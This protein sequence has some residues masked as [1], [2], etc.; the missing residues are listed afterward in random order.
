MID[1][2][3]MGTVVMLVY[4]LFAA[5]IATL[6]VLAIVALVLSIR[7]LRIRIAQA[8][9]PRPLDGI[10]DPQRRPDDVPPDDSER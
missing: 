4:V 9:G 2:G 3:P 1:V 10:D 5:A 6:A 7:L 8:T